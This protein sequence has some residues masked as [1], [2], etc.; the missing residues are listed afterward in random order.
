MA[1]PDN[2][3]ATVRIGGPAARISP[4]IFGGLAEHF[5]TSVNDGM[6]D[7]STGEAR[8]DVKAAITAMGVGLIRYPGGCYSAAYHWKDGV[9]PRDQRPYQARTMWTELGERL[10]SMLTAV[11][12]LTPE[13]LGQLMGP[14]EPNLVGT[15]EFLQYCV[16]IG[17]EPLLVANLG[18]GRPEEAAEWVRYT[19]RPASPRRVR[20]WGVGNETYGSHEPGHA[21]P[22]EYG[23]RLAEFSQAMKAVDPGIRIIGVGLPAF[24]PELASDPDGLIVAYDAREW[25]EGVL[26]AAAADI[27]ALS[28]HWYF[29][30][31]VGRPLSGLD[32]Y[33]QLVTSPDLL[34]QALTHTIGLVD[35]LTGDH[36]LMFSVDEWNRMVEL[37][38]HF[39]TNHTLADAGFFA[40]V[41]TVLLNHADRVSISC[42]SHLVNCLAPIQAPAPGQ[43]FP[44]AAYLIG[45]LYAG[46]ATGTTRQVEVNADQ[47]LV[48]ALT[49]I[50]VIGPGG[51]AAEPRTGR[52]LVAAATTAGQRNVIFLTSRH[53]DRPTVVTVTGLPV[54]QAAARW[55]V[56]AGPDLFAANTL[57]HP[58][59]LYWSEDSIAVTGGHAE[60]TLPPGGTGALIVGPAAEDQAS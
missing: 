25:N 14:P 60:V 19:M 44:T 21:P 34:D 52:G 8:A 7:R 57:E 2:A 43:M 46:L 55:R 5:G 10:G 58:G 47:V 29:P 30:G 15:D 51:L 31:M 49:G 23:K 41:Y 45:Q 33:A 17:A 38:D 53:L 54:A 28:L 16:D 27:D 32:D 9:G 22:A 35:E 36:R 11:P 6:W 39:G 20:W 40:G 42:I 37:E 13:R 56:L 18:T 26:G 4:S 1:Q 59:T 48:P 50:Q 24:P 12:G 3:R